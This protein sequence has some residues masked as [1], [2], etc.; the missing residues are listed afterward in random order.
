M[1]HAPRNLQI[2]IAMLVVGFA[3]CPTTVRSPDSGLQNTG[4]QRAGF[5]NSAGTPTNLSGAAG[6]SR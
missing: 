2:S 4:G 3:A 1:K 5:R 6:I